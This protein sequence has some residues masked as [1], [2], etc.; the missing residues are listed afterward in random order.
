MNTLYKTNTHELKSVGVIDNSIKPIR[1][2][3]RRA[4]MNR[5]DQLDR[6]AIRNSTDDIVIDIHEDLKAASNID[7]DND[8][9]SL[10]ITYLIGANLLGNTDLTV[11]VSDGT[12]LI[13]G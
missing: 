5:I 8:D 10:G 12:E 3:S 11:L 1:V 13:R 2:I 6:I 7:L 4:F 9:V